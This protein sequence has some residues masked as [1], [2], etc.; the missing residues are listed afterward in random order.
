YSQ[1]GNRSRERSSGNR[2]WLARSRQRVC[3]PSPSIPRSAPDRRRNHLYGA[4]RSTL[5]EGG[6]QLRLTR[7]H[8]GLLKP[9]ASLPTFRY[10]PDPVASGSVSASDETC[11]CCDQARGFLYTGPIYSEEDVEAVC[12][13]CIA[14]GSANEE[15]DAT[16]V[17]SEAFAD[18][19]PDAAIEEIC[20][21]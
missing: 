15:F 8:R 6:L 20:E 9:I 18:G 16:F 4:Q 2:R 3:A 7:A 13:W 10:H 1:S 14:D 21:R 17:D 12:P 5:V 11:P 19:I